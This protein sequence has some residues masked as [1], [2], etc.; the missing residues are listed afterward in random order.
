[1]TYEKRALLAALLKLARERYD[2]V[3]P[4]GVDCD[5]VKNPL[6]LSIEAF[7]E[8]LSDLGGTLTLWVNVREGSIGGTTKTIKESELS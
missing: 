8:C 1:M 2:D 4:C 6:G 5:D 3:V 7:K